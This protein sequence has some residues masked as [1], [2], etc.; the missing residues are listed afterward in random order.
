MAAEISIEPE[1]L[2]LIIRCF[3]QTIITPNLSISETDGR[4]VPCSRQCLCVQTEVGCLN[5]I[6]SFVIYLLE[7]DTVVSGSHQFISD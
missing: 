1:H 5:S 3:D 4:E 6:L 7:S 2:K